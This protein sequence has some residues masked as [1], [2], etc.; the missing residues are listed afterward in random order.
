MEETSSRSRRRWFARFSERRNQQVRNSWHDVCYEK[1]W[2]IN[3]ETLKN[4]YRVIHVKWASS[5]WPTDTVNAAVKQKAEE[6]G[7]K[8]QGEI[9]TAVRKSLTSSQNQAIITNYFSKQCQLCIKKNCEVL[10]MHQTKYF[11]SPMFF[12]Y[13]CVFSPSLAWIIKSLLY[14]E[15]FLLALMCTYT[16]Q[17]FSNLQQQHCCSLYQHLCHKV[18]ILWKQWIVFCWE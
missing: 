8:D 7:G 15:I 2:N 9:H 10:S 4:G 3:E 11:R 5:T 13:S 17:C 14:C 12:N 16:V 1:F 6:E 18:N